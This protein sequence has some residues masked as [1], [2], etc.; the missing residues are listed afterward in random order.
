MHCETT[1]ISNKLKCYAFHFFF[2]FFSFTKLENRRA[3]QVLARGWGGLAP[4]GEG[5]CW[6]KGIGK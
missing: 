4:V 1:F 6:G 5:R 3:K 2:S